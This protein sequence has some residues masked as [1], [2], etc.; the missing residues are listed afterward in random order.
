MVPAM[1]T[2]SIGFAGSL[3]LPDLDLSVGIMYLEER[4]TQLPRISINVPMYQSVFLN[5]EAPQ[6]FGQ[7]SIIK[8]M[9]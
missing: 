9:F 8:F 3:E 7:F 6:T 1:Y 4:R 2:F 5:N